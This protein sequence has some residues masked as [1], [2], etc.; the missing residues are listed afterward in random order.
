MRA[1]EGLS[2]AATV[3]AKKLTIFACQ[4]RVARQAQTPGQCPKIHSALQ[5]KSMD[6]F[7]F[8][9][10]KTK[11]TIHELVVLFAA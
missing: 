1:R 11:K 8:S 2:S 3:T 7:V 4:C 5:Y 6:Q 10:K 9:M